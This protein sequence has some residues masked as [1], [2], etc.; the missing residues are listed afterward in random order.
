MLGVFPG[1][2]LAAWQGRRTV[3]VRTQRSE[4]SQ[5]ETA[6]V[7]QATFN[8]ED[9]QSRFHRVSA[10]FASPWTECEIFR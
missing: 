1:R 6:Y 9:V 4:Q 3:E 5:H 10:N 2:T 8:C 7:L